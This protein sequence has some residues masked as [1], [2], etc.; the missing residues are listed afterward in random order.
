MLQI[1]TSLKFYHLVKKL[2]W[3][4]TDLNSQMDDTE[5]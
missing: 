3:F 1:W 2:V 4:D 5:W